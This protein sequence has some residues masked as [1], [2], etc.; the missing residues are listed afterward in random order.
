MTS[1]LPINH[2]INNVNNFISDVKSSNQAHYVF[3]ARHYPWVNANGVNDDTAIQVVNT[4]VAQAELDIYNEMLFGKLVQAS[5]V[6]HVIPRYNWT[7]NTVYAQYDQ[8]DSALYTKQFYVVTTGAGDQYNVYK[9]LYNNKG[10]PS[11]IKPSLQNTRGTFETGDGYIWKYMYTI[12]STANT[13]FTSTNF[14]PVAANTQVQ[15]NSVPGTIDV[16][17]VAN[18]GSGYNVYET[19][20]VQAI[21]N[22]TNIKISSNSSS[23]NNYYT[24]SSIYLKSGFGS[25]QVREISSYDGTSK[26]VSISNPIDIYVRFDLGNTSFITGGGA[27]GEK[28]EQIIDTSTFLYRVGYVSTGANVVQSDSGVAASVITSNSSALTLSRFNTGTAF[29]NSLP[30]RETSDTGTATSS[31]KGNVSNSTS[32]GLGV[33]TYSGTG[34]DANGTITITSATG[35]GGVANAQVSSG[36]VTTIN[37]ANSGNGYATIPTVSVSAP[38]AQTFNANTA[39]TGGTGEGANNVIAIGT[40]NLFTVNDQII[41]YIST[42][43]TAIGG[44]SSNTTYYVQFANSTIVALSATSNTAAGNRI[45]LTKGLS[46]TGHF[47]QGKTATATIYPSSFVV[48]N[49]TATAFTT[50]YANNDFIRFGENANTNIRRIMTVNATTITVNHPFD[51][52]D[53]SANTFKMSIAIEP[54]TISTTF[55]NGII[56][57]TST[58]SLKLSITNTSVIGAS[59]IVGERVDMVTTANVALGANGTIAFSN[60]GTL[61]I[62]GIAGSNTWVSG[63]RVK[64]ASSLLTADITSVDSYPNVTIKNPNGTFQIGRSVNFSSSSTANTGIAKLVDIVNLSQDVVEYEIGP[65]VKITG[66]GTGAVAVATV[67]TSV[68][69][70]NAISRIDV[71]NPGSNYTEATISIYANSSY[72]SNGSATALISPLLGHGADPMYELGARYAGLNIKFDT[73]SNESWYFPSDIT[74]RK[75]GILKNPKFANVNITLT[76]FDRIRLTTN[77]ISGWTNGEI[78]VQ[79]T[80]NAAGIVTTSNSSTVELKNVKGTFITS[81]TNTIYGYSSGSLAQVANTQVLRFFANDSISQLDG[82]SAKVGVSSS[83]TELY[84]TEVQGRFTNGSVIYNTTNSYAT[85]NS[86]ST[87]DK[88][89]NLATTFGLR[90]NQTSRITLASNT[91]TYTNNEFV[92]QTTTGAKG[93][94]I[95]GRTDLDLSI[96]PGTGSFAIGDTIYNSSNTA[97]AKIFFAN[98]TYLKLTSVSN[99]SAFPSANVINNGLGANA[100]IANAYSVLLVSDITKTPNF[101]SGN[102]SHTVVGNTSGANGVVFAVTPPDLIRETGKVMYLET[103]N[104]V[105]SRGIN[106]TEEIRLVIKF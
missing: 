41:Y 57:N 43:N 103:S 96:T 87:A 91:G 42:G 25:G 39:V 4:S 65:T 63:Q 17:K 100:T 14:I 94:V 13:K 55:A 19:G 97:N 7:S 5:D 32:L 73:T 3:A 34:Y 27:V 51:S 77:S 70:A 2:H 10:Q 18:G 106:S 9:C 44:L 89:R 95:S 16:I 72:G 67:N 53:S 40:A 23:F 20:Q 28:M 80:T 36:K 85:I 71:I 60:S 74:V 31:I 101:T 30:I 90:F 33:L 38:V 61:F 59:F 12:D 86:I 15:G 21:I 54:D 1:I 93:R 76:D 105:I 22:R 64:G 104:T 29:S 75:L 98:S 92:T 68:G 83:N 78:V 48:T 88:T 102:T 58:D 6:T 24:N 11:T 49:A 79:S 62:A 69:T 26:V 50:E 52:S 99:T 81:T 8:N 37:I 35:T 56:S 84:L 46:E 82:T 47:L 45:A 66:D